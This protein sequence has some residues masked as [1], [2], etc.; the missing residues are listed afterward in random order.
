MQLKIFDKAYIVQARSGYV[1]A[2][3]LYGVKDCH[4]SDFPGASCLPFNRAE[5]GFVGIVLKLESQFV[6]VMMPGTSETPGIS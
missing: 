3:N 6:I 2:V 1:I 5:D 4:R